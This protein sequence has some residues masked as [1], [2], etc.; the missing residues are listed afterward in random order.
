MRRETHGGETQVESTIASALDWLEQIVDTTTNPSGMAD[1][2]KPFMHN[3]DTTRTN[4]LTAID[5]SEASTSVVEQA[6]A[7]AQRHSSCSLHFLHVNQSNDNE[8]GRE[9]RRF[10]L[11]EWLGARLPQTDDALAG[12]NVIAHEASGDPW[13]VIVQMA[14]DLMTDLVVLGTHGRKGLDRVMMGSVA[15]AVS[16]HCG[17]SVLVVR[18]KAHEHSLLPLEPI[19]GV[20]VE[21]RLQSQGNV[22]WCHDHTARRDRRHAHY[23]RGIGQW[24]RQSDG[25]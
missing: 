2:V 14:S 18:R 13:H 24:V 8:D 6:I 20:C 9:G 5:Y 11:L 19:C 22:L 12:I 7:T 25:G 15:E 23:G 4:I 21:A 3:A 16:R 10:E 1:A 17:C